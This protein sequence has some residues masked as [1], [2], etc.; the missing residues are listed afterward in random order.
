MGT[1]G[2][3]PGGRCVHRWAK[4]GMASITAR[5]FGE[6][7]RTCRLL[8][9]E[10][11]RSTLIDPS[12]R[13]VLVAEA[14]FAR[15]LDRVVPCPDLLGHT[16]RARAEH[17]SRVEA[18]AIWR[19][20]SSWNGRPPLMTFDEYCEFLCQF[21]LLELDDTYIE[22]DTR[23]HDA[24]VRGRFVEFDAQIE[25]IPMGHDSGLY[26]SEKSYFG[27]RCC[28]ARARCSKSSHVV[29]ATAVRGGLAVRPR[30]WN[31]AG[32]PRSPT[33]RARHVRSGC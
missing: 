28:L 10:E 9:G 27:A 32:S 25:R 11:S 13:V 19:S 4:N 33:H 23:T 5:L 3:S 2:F 26:W 22:F 29:P 17:E 8:Q 7:D 6:V 20:S 1:A 18:K 16:D 21:P 31:Q 30:W 14:A 15:P 24:R 12:H